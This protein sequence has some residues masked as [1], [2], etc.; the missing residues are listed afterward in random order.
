VLDDLAIL[1]AEDASA[2]AVARHATGVAR[3]DRKRAAVR[4]PPHKPTNPLIPD[5]GIRISDDLAHGA[6][7]C[8]I[9][10]ASSELGR[11]SRA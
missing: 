9:A 10:M 7:D 3:N 11:V 5:D 8:C 6:G 2:V 4:N 1:K